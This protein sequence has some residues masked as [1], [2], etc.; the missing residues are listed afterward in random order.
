MNDY[1]NATSF[2]LQQKYGGILEAYVGDMVCYYWLADNEQQRLDVYQQTLL[3]AIEMQALQQSFFSTLQQRYKNRIDKESL[4]QISSII[5]AGIGMSV[6]N[7]VMGDLGPESGVKKFGI[8]GDPLNLAARIEGLTRLFTTDMI[9]SGRFLE[10]ITAAGLVGRRLG[11]IKV[12]G[13]VSEEMLYALGK[14]NNLHFKAD[15]I[16]QWEQWLDSVEQQSGDEIECPDCY[17]KDKATITDWL[18]RGLL[19]D[20]GVWLLDKK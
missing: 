16:K 14:E 1:L 10:A 5:D 4:Q 7:V 2:V 15:N 17:Q 6:G 11:K 20:E 13:R 18:N 3:A 12:K 9:V 8:L 19:S